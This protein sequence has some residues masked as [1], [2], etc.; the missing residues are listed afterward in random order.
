MND[1]IG[2]L[3]PKGNNPNPLTN[4]PYSESYTNLSSDP[5]KGWSFY[6]A[7]TKSRDILKSLQDYQLTFIISGTG[8]GKTVLLPKFALHYT[9]YEG[10][11]GVTLPKKNATVSAAEFAAKTLDVPVGQDVGYVHKGSPKE[12]LSPKSKLVYMTDGTLVMKQVRDKYLSEY[13]VII[14]DEA[15]ERKV[16]IDVILLFLKE[17]LQSGKRPDL[18]VIIMS[19]TIDGKKYQNYFDGVKSNIINISGKPNYDIDVHYLD[20]PV[21][22]YI[23]E[24]ISTIDEIQKHDIGDKLFFITTSAEAVQ[25]CKNIR[26]KYPNIYCIEVYA[27]MDPKKRLFAEERDTFRE[28]GDYNTKLVIATNVAES[29]ITIDGLKYVIDSCYEFHNSYDPKTM[30]YIMEKK[31]ITQAQALQR[32]GRVG[33][34]EPGICYHLLTKQQFDALEQY[35]A[36]DILEQ[37][38]TIDLLKII[39]TS[40]NKTYHDGITMLNKL[41]DV[42]HKKNIDVSHGL[43]KLYSIIDSNGSLTKIGS[44]ITEFSTLNLN[45]SLFLIYSYQLMC[46]REASYIIAMINL[47]KGNIANI[48]YKADTICESDCAKQSSK[49]FLKKVVQKEGDHLTFL[50]IYNEFKETSDQKKWANKFGIRMDVL[51]KVK[52][53]ADQMYYRVI[54]ISKAYQESRVANVDVNL[55]LV[56]ALYLSHQHM[57]AERMTPIYPSEKNEAEIQSKSTVHHFYTNK[58]LMKKTF[59]YNEF[60]RNSGKWEF[61]CVT[62][63]N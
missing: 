18:R 26:P 57:I 32:R 17:I 59:I 10:K 6:P 2:I 58:E 51:N 63:I 46:A 55:R 45:Q 28:L 53:E 36:P 40:E 27:D 8:S 41:M 43:Y 16:Q 5:D 1:K 48:F 22:N 21:T 50:K 61:T 30:G 49:S 31:M 47:L 7:Y 4:Q 20:T 37:D 52:R 19:A 60:I 56:K 34:T 15:H 23:K 38:I 35:P 25:V 33:R 3:D 13:N 9:N 54:N 14:I 44:E 62:I 42:P 24:G 11:V 12:M 29:S 39:Q